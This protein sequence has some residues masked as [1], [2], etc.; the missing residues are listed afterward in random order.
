MR[1]LLAFYFNKQAQLHFVHRAG[2][3]SKEEPLGYFELR[4]ILRL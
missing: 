3:F 1:Q 2:C 4:D